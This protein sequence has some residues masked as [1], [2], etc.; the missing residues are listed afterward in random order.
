MYPPPLYLELS[1]PELGWYLLAMLTV[2]TVSDQSDLNPGPV[3]G[4]LSLQS[5][6][7]LL[8]PLSLSGGVLTL[9]GVSTAPWSPLATSV[10]SQPLSHP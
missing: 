10:T 9:T 3:S 4:D 2:V 8:Y 5:L 1:Y 7:T 6:D